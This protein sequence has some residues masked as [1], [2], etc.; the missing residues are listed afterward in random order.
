[1]LPPVAAGPVATAILVDDGR[2]EDSTRS[3]CRHE[4]LL[5]LERESVPEQFAAFFPDWS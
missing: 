5:T 4:L 3:N 2:V 1:M